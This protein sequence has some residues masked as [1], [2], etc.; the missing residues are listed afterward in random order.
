MDFLCQSLQEG[1][2]YIPLVF[3][4]EVSRFIIKGDVYNSDSQI[5]LQLSWSIMTS[6]EA[7]I[8]SYKAVFDIAGTSKV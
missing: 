6:F 8:M 2:Q 3:A 5:V 1:G 7:S 4:S